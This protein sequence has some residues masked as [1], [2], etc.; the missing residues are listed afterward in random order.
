MERLK[1]HKEEQ[2]FL[3]VELRARRGLEVPLS[4]PWLLNFLYEVLSDY[5]QSVVQPIAWIGYCFAF[6]FL[7]LGVT[8][9]FNGTHLTRDTAVVLSFANIFSFLPI[10]REIMTDEM[11]KGLSYWVQAIGVFQS[12]FGAILLFLVGLALRNRFRLK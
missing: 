8:S 5:G 12:L 11:I 9:R 2:M 10:R 4:G 6:G 1:K 7:A 3:C